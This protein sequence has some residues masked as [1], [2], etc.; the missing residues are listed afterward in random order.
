MPQLTSAT[1]KYRHH[2]AS[3][4][5][6]VTLDGHDYYLGPHGTRASRR[7]YDRLM[8]EWLAGGRRLPT[9]CHDLAVN[10]VLARFW[11]F[12]AQHYRKNGQ[13]TGE[14]DNIRHALRP[15]AHRYGEILAVEFGPLA[16]KTVRDEMIAGGLC[17]NVINQRIGIIKRVFRWAASEELLP[18]TTYQAL[19]T[20]A[21]LKRGRT[22][23]RESK[24]IE[25][26]SDAAVD[27]TLPFLPPVVADMVRFQ[28]L[29]G[30]R[31]HEVC[32]LR[33]ADIERT[34]DIWIYRPASH[35]LEHHEL[36][37]QIL[38]GPQAQSVLRP[39]LLREA[40]QFCFSPAESEA[41]RKAELRKRRKTKVQPSQLDRKTAR[42]QHQPGTCYKTTAY[43]YAVQRAAAKA[44]VAGWSP[45]RLRHATATAVRRDF[46]LEAAQIILGHRRADTTQIYAERD[47][48]RA[49]AVIREVG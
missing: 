10:E 48:E 13:P 16:L 3:G 11:V 22:G 47:L 41:R 31:P 2:K 26:V 15:V 45:N 19:A 39:Y 5:A 37:R 9:A 33:P 21:G 38:I 23:A 7:A 43:G 6:V 24:R 42:P 1:P 12:A 29:T 20:V 4:Q 32:H 36:E 27:A 46:G 34:D 18:V 30:C 28:R 17:R 25:P 40:T 35:K 14:I 8:G 49:R 44:G